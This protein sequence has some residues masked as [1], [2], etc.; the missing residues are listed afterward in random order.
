MS[1]DVYRFWSSIG[2]I[3]VL[4]PASLLH[5]FTPS[6]LHSFTPSFP[7]S[8]TPSLPLRHLETGEGL[9][10][11]K[12]MECS[13]ENLNFIPMRDL[14]GRC[15]SFIIPLKDGTWNGIGSI[16]SYCSRE[17]PVGTSRLDS[18]NRE[19]SRNQAWK[20]K[21]SVSFNYYYFE[22]TLDDTWWCFVVSSPSETRI[23]DLYRETS[24][25]LSTFA[26]VRVIYH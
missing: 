4:R 9:S 15:L 7:H 19:I 26:Y 21:L 3:D 6:L 20:Q 13:C 24:S 25:I 5:S 14:C 1:I 12:D 11:W 17:D 8:F 22:C 2:I 23:L 16:T 10:I 18:R